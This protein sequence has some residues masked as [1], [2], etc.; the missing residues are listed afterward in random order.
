MW[1]KA[2]QE[3]YLRWIYARLVNNTKMYGFLV[4]YKRSTL[5]IFGKTIEIIWL[6][7]L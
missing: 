7:D 2:M 4:H 5:R 1:S 6:A 3:F